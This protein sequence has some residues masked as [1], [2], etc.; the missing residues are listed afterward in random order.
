MVWPSIPIGLTAQRPWQTIVATGKARGPWTKDIL[1]QLPRGPGVFMQG[2]L[3]Y[4]ADGTLVHERVLEDA[5]VQECIAMAE[6]RSMTLTAYCGL[7]IFAAATD[8]HTDRLIFYAEPTP[9][10]MGL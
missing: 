6:E 5:V 8:E 3:V 1:P 2:L 9:E 4:D 10:G 7:R